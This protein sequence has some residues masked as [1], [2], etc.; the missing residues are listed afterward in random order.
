M[1]EE[2]E[3]LE[4]IR[5]DYELTFLTA[6]AD[7]NAAIW[8]ILKK[9]SI[10]PYYQSQPRS[11]RIAYEIKKQTA[12]YLSYCHFL[13][14][15]EDL[16]KIRHDLNFETNVLRYL[17]ITP[18]LKPFIRQPRQLSRTPETSQPPEK[19]A[20]VLSNEVLE[21]KLEEILK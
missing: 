12:A 15:A 11:V 14:P 1:A 6:N 8:A 5:K 19:R 17:I 16:K 10:E 3:D 7:H 21:Q 13:A 9:Y 20:T 4:E 18:P 2:Q